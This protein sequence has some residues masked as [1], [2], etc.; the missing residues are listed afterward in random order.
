VAPRG[1]YAGITVYS[2]DGITIGAPATK[3]KLRGLTVNGRGGNH[4]IVVSGA[5]G[6]EIVDCEVSGMKLDGLRMLS[7]GDLSVADSHFIGNT[8]R[9]VYAQG[10]GNSGIE[11]AR[12]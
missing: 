2:G 12:P 5:A 3:V 10:G 1:V 6:V 8:G 9:G 11:A 7:T 4:G